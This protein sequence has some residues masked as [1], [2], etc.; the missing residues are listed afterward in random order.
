MGSK[1]RWKKHRFCTFGASERCYQISF[2]VSQ[3]ILVAQGRVGPVPD[4]ALER[5]G[6]TDSVGRRSNDR[7]V[8]LHG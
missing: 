7:G 8:T 2:R 4:L 5:R 6:D 3:G 1:S